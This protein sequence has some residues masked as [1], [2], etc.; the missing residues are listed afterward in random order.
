MHDLDME[1]EQ[2]L[3]I[4]F[5]SIHLSFRRMVC[6]VQGRSSLPEKPC[7]DQRYGE[8]SATEHMPLP[9]AYRLRDRYDGRLIA[10]HAFDTDS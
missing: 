5:I 4:W 3:G 8:S 7:T 1:G 9:K 10:V 6:T 2:L